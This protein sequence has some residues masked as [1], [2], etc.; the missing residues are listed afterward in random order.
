MKNLIRVLSVILALVMVVGIV[1]ACGKKNNDKES[2]ND[3]SSK[4][5]YQDIDDADAVERDDFT[6]VYET[7]GAGIT[8]DD[9]T[10]KDDGTATVT[11]DGVTYEL[12]MDFL[13][14]AMVYNTSVPEGSKYKTEEEV[15]N[16][17]WKLY[18]QRWNLLVAEIP[19]YSN[20][21]YDLYNAKFQNFVTSPYWGAV[22][23]IIKT[24]VKEGADNSAILGS[25]TD[26]SGMFRNASWGKSS[27]AASD[28]DVMSLTSGYS[29][30]YSDIT[31][32]Y[33]W[34]MQALAEEPTSKINEDGTL[35]YTI[36]IRD[37]MK[38]S[39]NSAIDARNYIV[40]VLSNS[41]PVAVEAGG[42]GSAGR[43]LV[44]YDAFKKG[45]SKYF[46]GVQLLDDYTFAVTFTSDYAGYYYAMTNA[47]F[48]P[49]PLPLYLGTKGAITVDPET[50]ACG[51]NE[52]YYEKNSDGKYVVAAE[53]VANM[54]WDS[55]LPYS[56]PYKVTNY[57]DSDKTA[58][59]T[60]NPVYPG[61]DARGK[62]SIETIHY[63]KVVSETQMDQFKSGQV[64]VIAGITGGKDTEAALKIV[65]D[66]PE[67]YAETHYDRAGYG[68]IGFRA[69]W[70]PVQFKEVRQAIMYTI[71]RPEFAATFTGGYGS[72]VHGPYYTGFSAYKA[73]EN[74][75]QLNAYT[76]SSDSAIRVLEAGGWIYNKEGKTFV[77]GTDDVRYKKL[78]GYEKSKEN[79]HFKTVD[80]KYAT[81]KINGEYYM[82]LAITWYGTQP[83]EVTD[84]LVTA[85]QNN[86]T[87]T[88]DIGMYIQYISTE[89][90]PG[91]YGEYMRS[92]E[93]GYDGTPKLCAINFATS[94]SSAAYD[95]AFNWTIDPDYYDTYSA[96]YIM[97]DADFYADYSKSK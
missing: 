4:V 10:E 35:T 68:K 33:I 34:N 57:N 81:V 83:N 69:D 16:Q 71:N 92:E 73:V 54:K 64:D 56:G 14:M 37:D 39:D 76:Y 46:S 85:W 32:N 65:K 49:D 91:L 79:L 44:G 97:D 77:K 78:S 47:G 15:Y 45:D 25:S 50:K 72:V 62:P 61:D 74:D 36:K 51:L 22:D 43:T 2:K 21:Y 70:S 96:Y 94:F 24:T 75:I 38:F 30:V 6:S 95:F 7:I 19:L 52:D 86:P 93:D 53:I 63:V 82:P 59:L 29:T 89:F 11:V 90:I 28:N 13:S 60:L 58:T 84:L 9:V 3:D 12:G 27:P 5:V 80:G 1:A 66:N 31:G 23:A 42:S 48:S 8:I 88:T 40:A 87:A 41:T 55:P 26:L 67:K 17:W 20:E 18:I